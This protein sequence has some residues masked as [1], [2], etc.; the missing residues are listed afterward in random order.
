M[1]VN[2]D[3]VCL[4]LLPPCSQFLPSALSVQQPPQFL[5][6]QSTLCT[7]TTINCIP[8]WKYRP[9]K[10]VWQSLPRVIEPTNTTLDNSPAGNS[11]VLHPRGG[12]NCFTITTQSLWSVRFSRAIIPTPAGRACYTLNYSVTHANNQKNDGY[13]HRLLLCLF[14]SWSVSL[15][16]RFW[17]MKTDTGSRTKKGKLLDFSTC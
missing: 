9:P 13:A 5:P 4:L 7:Q 1:C 8:N 15:S 11:R 6:H 17:C 2:N 14:A 12:R 16:P 10:N 3:L